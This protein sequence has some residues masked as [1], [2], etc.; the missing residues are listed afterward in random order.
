MI[1]VSDQEK[2]KGWERIDSVHLQNQYRSSYLDTQ[3]DMHLQCI[4]VET[5]MT[6]TPDL[7]INQ[8]MGNCF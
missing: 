2:N 1:V 4:P 7:D 5:R 6:G 8:E 3:R